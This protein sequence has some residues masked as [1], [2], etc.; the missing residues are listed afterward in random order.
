MG[1]IVFEESEKMMPVEELM[2]V[3]TRKKIRQGR[4]NRRVI[5]LAP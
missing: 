4:V 1:E 5:D 3:E 2:R